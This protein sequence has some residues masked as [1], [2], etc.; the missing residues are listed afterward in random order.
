M[1][2]V[3]AAALAKFKKDEPEQLVELAKIAK[4]HE[5]A[6]LVEQMKE[7]EEAIGLLQQ[8]LSR[9]PAPTHRSRFV[10]VQA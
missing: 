9:K 7:S 6:M 3:A 1:R 5:L 10:R 2:A 8:E 4:P